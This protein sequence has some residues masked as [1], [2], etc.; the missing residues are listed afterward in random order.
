MYVL[1]RNKHTVVGAT[2]LLA[3]LSVVGCGAAPAATDGLPPAE[4][5]SLASVFPDDSDPTMA[6]QP[7]V[8][9]ELVVQPFPG[10]DPLALSAIYAQANATVVDE[11]PELG[12]IAVRVDPA[13]LRLVADELVASGLI[14]AVHKDYI[15]QPSE[16][17]ND[18]E[19]R[20]QWHLAEIDAESAWDLAVGSEEIPIAI[21]DTGVDTNHPDLED[22]IANVWNA[23]D[24]S[25]DVND[26]M[27]HGTKVAGVAAAIA[28][29]RIGVAG[30]AWDSPLYVVRAT[31]ARGNTSGR[32]LAAGITWAVGQGARVINVSFAPLWSNKVVEAAAQRAFSR[33]AIVFIS[34]GNAGRNRDAAGY[35]DAVFVAATDGLGDLADFSDHGR[36]VDVA[37]PGTSIRTTAVD[38]GYRSPSGTSFASPMVAGLAALAWSTNPELRPASILKA[39]TEG[40]IDLGARGKD[41]EFG[42]GLINAREVVE[43]AA[44]TIVEGDDSP[45]TISITRP[46]R[47]TALK[48]RYTA[49]VKA[50]DDWR[51][52][53]VVL[54]IDG[55][56]LATDTRAPYRLVID[57]AEFER[58]E[59]ELTF[60]A[61]DLAGNSSSASVTVN[62]RDSSSSADIDVQFKSP[63]PGTSVTGDVSIK[64][65]IT[66][67]GDIETMEWLVDG[68][69]VFV[70]AVSGR[71]AGV[72][73]VWHAADAT[74]GEHTITLIATDARGS[75][76]VGTLRL[77]RR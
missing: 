47:G 46:R 1:S 60:T 71:S 76:G 15:Y 31:D 69:S 38:G 63:A 50:A 58:G 27:G 59:H 57:T 73:F 54:S 29:N 52:A 24:D 33:G 26:E 42:H 21:I 70:G 48:G 11:L 68:E 37:A 53:D 10:A 44:L 30:V 28:D 61:T 65:T 49:S 2:V 62:F 72:S 64:A 66:S 41:D 45:P 39:L 19:F 17:P 51:V 35:E 34:A 36:F 25:T 14:E 20:R 77:Y 43:Y 74:P 22:K 18:P 32:V 7:F 56:P 6:Q 75:R 55:V 4:N 23:Y 16:T 13:A 9:N 67:S 3:L 12:L 5:E 8:E 40:S